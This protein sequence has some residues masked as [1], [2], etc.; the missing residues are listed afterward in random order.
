MARGD[1]LDEVWRESVAALDFVRK[2]KFGQVVVLSIQEFVEGLR[3]QARGANRVDGA[4][5]EARVLRNGV[6]V[7]ACFHWILQ[8]QRHFLRSDASTE[9]PFASEN[10]RRPWER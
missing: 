10:G 5:L 4:T 6:A 1:P 8:L 2:Y 9:R 7:V 3:G